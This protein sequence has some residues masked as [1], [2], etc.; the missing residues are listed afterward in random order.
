[1]KTIIYGSKND[2]S[3]KA[4]NIKKRSSDESDN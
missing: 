1:M 3:P 2:E 4:V